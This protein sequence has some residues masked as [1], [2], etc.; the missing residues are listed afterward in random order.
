MLANFTAPC[1]TTKVRS[2]GQAVKTPPFHGGIM[3]S[4]PIGTTTK[5]KGTNIVPFI[6]RSDYFNNFNQALISVIEPSS[7]T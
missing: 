4:I 3:G 1:Y 7:A 6:L 5:I 2:R